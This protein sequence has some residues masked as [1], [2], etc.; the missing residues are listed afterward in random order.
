MPPSA[1]R[2]GVGDAVSTA[3]RTDARL[4]EEREDDRAVPVEACAVGDPRRLASRALSGTLVIAVV[5][6]TNPGN[7]A[8][9]PT[10]GAQ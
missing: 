7:A 4:L 3:A 9:M 6:K 10:R 1:L 5:Q 2:T 8:R